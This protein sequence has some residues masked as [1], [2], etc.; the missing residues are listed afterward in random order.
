MTTTTSSSKPTPNSK[1]KVSSKPMQYD[2]DPTA[3]TGKVALT[4]TLGMQL[5]QQSLA[6]VFPTMADSWWANPLAFMAD[7]FTLLA[8][9]GA[10]V[11][12]WLT[13]RKRLQELKK[14]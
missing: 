7:L 2:Y 11:A 12:W 13:I 9:I 5:V 8:A 14:K 1:H 10:C 4:V 3:F 6:D